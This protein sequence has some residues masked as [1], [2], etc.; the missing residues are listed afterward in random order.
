MV[1]GGEG[2]RILDPGMGFGYDLA[3]DGDGSAFETVAEV[4]LEEGEEKEILSK[5]SSVRGS[6]NW[7]AIEK[8]RTC[9]TKGVPSFEVL[10]FAFPSSS[11]LSSVSIPLSPFS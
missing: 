7:W 2:V 10:A 9:G 4:E 3:H 6:L 1:D 8:K 5:S 11:S